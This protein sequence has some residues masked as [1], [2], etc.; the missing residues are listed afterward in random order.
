MKI[1]DFN[2][3][4]PQ[5]LIP[6]YPERSRE[7][8]RLMVVH[9]GTGKIEHKLFKDVIDYFEEGDTFAVN[10]SKV[11]PWLLYANKDRIESKIDVTLLRELNSKMHMWD[12]KVEPA[13]KIRVGNK[14]CF[15]NN[16]L[17]AEV[18]DNTTSRGRTLKFAFSGSSEELH[19]VLEHMGYM[20]VPIDLKRKPEDSDRQ[21]YQTIYATQGGGVVA[22]AAGLHFISQM[23]KK[24]ELKDIN[25]VPITLHVSISVLDP[26]DVEDVS[27]YKTDAEKVI[28]G[29]NSADII[30]ATMQNGKRLC[31]VGTST[32]RAIESS[33]S[34]SKKVI[35]TDDWTNLFIH[36]PHQISACNALITNFHLP[37]SV[38]LINASAFTGVELLME[39]YNVAIKEGYKFFTY[40]DAMLVI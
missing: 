37:K 7:N 4:L 14:L 22:P 34:V 31:A 35:P 33:L 32:V 19:A 5:N 2:F 25:F 17:V 30:N 18:L 1:S 15:G 13:R 11:F 21:T 40:G 29:Q 10:D 20:P 3:V 16:D 36:N 26:I 27:K 38:P 8:D 23:L 24:I 28:I 9:K 39:A 6:K 12:A